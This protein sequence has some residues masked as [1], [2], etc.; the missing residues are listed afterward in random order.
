MTHV[1]LIRFVLALFVAL[2]T[3]SMALAGAPARA[4]TVEVEPNA[5]CVSAQNLGAATLPISVTG[6]LD[7]PPDTPDVDYFRITATPGDLIAVEQ[8]G[9]TSGNGTLFDPFLGVFSSSCAYL[10]YDDDGAGG[11]GGGYR[12]A[13]VEITVPADGVLVIAA[14]S[15]WDWEFSGYGYFAGSYRLAV[16]KVTTALGIGGR[17]VNANTGAAIEGATVWLYPACDG[18]DCW[19]YTQGYTFSGADG[20]FRFEPGNFS[21][22]DNILRTGGYKLVVDAGQSFL[23]YQGPPFQLL[24]GQDLDLGNV[25][26]QPVPVV[27]SIRGR[28][29]DGVTGDP[30]PGNVEPFGRAELQ[31]C[32]PVY[33]CWTARYADVDAQGN[34]VFESNQGNPLRAGSY[35]ILGRADQ[36]EA[37][38]G[39]EF[40][41]VADQHYDVGDFQVKSFPV[42]MN[43]LQ[44]CSTVPSTGGTC[45]YVVRVTNGNPG[46]LQGDVWSLVASQ[47]WYWGG[48]S[49]EFQAGR[50]TVSLLPGVSTDVTFSFAVPATLADNTAICARVFTSHKTNPFDSIG[51][52]D[53]FCM[54]KVGNTF[55]VMPDKQKRELLKKVK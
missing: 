13:R 34:F 25:G 41:T 29:V 47:P 23:G 2:G 21:L 30:L 22:Y 8:L 19:R 14:S 20:S 18:D 38:T 44:G 15:A 31:S 45:T 36:Y 46:K 39:P 53:L 55:Q 1:R 51:R 43:L 6:S 28:L 4:Q 32:S 52:R 3:L 54:A 10:G 5:T 9:E 37:T 42:R 49:T 12:D 40:E 24:E 27:G 7:T 48:Q 35:R 11:F 16:S 33:G 50:K 26:I 17:I